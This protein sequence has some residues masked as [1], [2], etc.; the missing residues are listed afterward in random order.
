[1]RWKPIRSIYHSELERLKTLDSFE[2]LEISRDASLAEAR[3]AYR[4]KITT[5]HPDGA[6]PFMKNYNQEVTKLLNAAYK[7]VVEDINTNG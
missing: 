6:D 1:M 5:Y 2:L 3:A 7:T 4:E